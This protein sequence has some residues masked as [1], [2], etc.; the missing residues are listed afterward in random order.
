M[1]RGKWKQTFQRQSAPPW[2]CPACNTGTLVIQP[3]T[4]SV[5]E[6]SFSRRSR[7]AEDWDFNDVNYSFAGLLQCNRPT[8]KGPVAICGT[9]GVEPIP[10]EE[11]GYDFEEYLE[12]RFLYPAPAI[13][14][15]PSSCPRNVRDQIEGA[16]SLFWSNLPA[17]ANSIRGSV[18]F[19]LDHLGLK[20]YE[21]ANGRRRRL[22]LH[23]RVELFKGKN[24]E[25]GEPLLALKWIGNEGSH[26]GA[27]TKDDLLDAFE[28]LDYIVDELFGNKRKSVRQLSK[29]IIKRKG[30]RSRPK[31]VRKTSSAKS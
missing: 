31:R 8:C 6:T 7:S 29:Q 2:P 4:I 11:G 10:D 27:L 24:A 1:D 22:S 9:G 13:I 12:A 21:Q 5:E 14:R 26:A 20:R 25:L 16:F 17:A 15:I 28:L 23:S 3:K 19:L 18:E 30:A